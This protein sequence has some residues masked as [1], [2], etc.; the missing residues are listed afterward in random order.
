MTLLPPHE[1]L[2]EGHVGVNAISALFYALVAL[3]VGDSF[4]QNH[5]GDDDGG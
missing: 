1:L 5:V 3:L 2:D 4:S